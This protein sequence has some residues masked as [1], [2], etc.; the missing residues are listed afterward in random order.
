[1][2]ITRDEAKRVADLA[3]LAFDEDGLARMAA[4]MSKILDYIDQLPA[5]EGAGA[6][7]AGM[8]LRE[9]VAREGVGI[10]DV[11]GNAPAFRDGYFVVPKVI[12][13]E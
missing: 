9:D 10:D 12:G 2:K 8:E 7:A 11:A 13:G 1:M 4:E 3:H 5:V 6:M